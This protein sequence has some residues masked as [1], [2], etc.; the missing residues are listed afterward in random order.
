MHLIIAST[1]DLAGMNIVDKLLKK[2]DW[3]EIGKF[4]GNPCYGAED[5]ALVTIN[6]Y[7][8]HCD[9][10]DLAVKE[11][12]GITLD[13]VIFASKHRSE[14]G[15]S[16]L[17]VHPIGNFSKAELGGRDR[18][19]VPS[20]PGIMTEAL[21]ILKVKTKEANLEYKVSLEATHHGPYLETPAFFIE[22]GSLEPQWRDEKA[23]DL[24]AETILEVEE[25]DYPVAVGVGGGHYAPRITDVALARRISFGH[26]IP[27]YAIEK[28]D[29]EILE[30]TISKT[31][32]VSMV[33]FHRK[34]MKKPDYRRLKEWFESKGLRTVRED[35]LE[36]LE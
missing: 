2:R 22:I 19:L 31:P 23:A 12:L 35:D 10:I 9:N 5:F 7:H 11:S 18:E 16:T 4:E 28:V 20:H 1:E 3:A 34:A 32:N 26:I 17:T 33:Y 15:L 27:S 36:R 13:V 25:N 24:I 6:H 21:R 14:S 29:D 8:L 30:T